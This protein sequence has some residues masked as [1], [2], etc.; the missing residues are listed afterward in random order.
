MVNR[1]NEKPKR[2]P[3]KMDRLFEIFIYIDKKFL[4]HMKFVIL[5]SKNLVKGI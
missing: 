5:S 2:P 3:I 4:S 1:N